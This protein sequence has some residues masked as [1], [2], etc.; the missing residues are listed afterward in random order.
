MVFLSLF[1]VKMLGCKEAQRWT[2]P[3]LLLSHLLLP[4]HLLLPLLDLLMLLSVVVLVAEVAL[5]SLLSPVPCLFSLLLLARYGM[6]SEVHGRSG[7]FRPRQRL[8]W[9]RRKTREGGG[10]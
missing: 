8:S 2:V 4:Y 10:S 9:N 6:H 5:L 3:L 7:R 1:L